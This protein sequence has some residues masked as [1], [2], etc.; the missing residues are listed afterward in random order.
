MKNRNKTNKLDTVIRDSIIR[1]FENNP[2]FTIQLKKAVVEITRKDKLINQDPKFN[3]LI[4]DAKKGLIYNIKTGK[5]YT[6]KNN[7]YVRVHHDGISKQAHRIIWEYVNGSIPKGYHIDHINGIK[8][9]NRIENL[10]LL[11]GPQN[12]QNRHSK[13][14]N[15]KSGS[16]IPGVSYC[17]HHKRFRVTLILNK[18]QY[19]YGYFD[20]LSE[21]ETIAL[22]ARRELFKFNTL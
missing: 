9:D 14:K 5:V 2:D 20:D 18:K 10:R 19:F 15:N 12:S 1:L 3:R 17:K 6:N 8:N 16:K 13:N 22:D 7:D 21:A 4:I 11:T